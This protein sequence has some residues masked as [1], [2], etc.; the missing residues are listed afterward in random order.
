MVLSG[1]QSEG[2]VIC[3]FV[4]PCAQPALFP[5]RSFVALPFLKLFRGAWPGFAQKFVL[6]GGSTECRVLHRTVFR[7]A[8][9]STFQLA[10]VLAIARPLT[11]ARA[12]TPFG[13]LPPLAQ[14]APTTCGTCSSPGCSTHRAFFKMPYF[15][16]IYTCSALY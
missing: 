14:R 7:C 10:T 5:L 1:Y 3:F 6:L 9:P 12:R 11:F 8:C 4:C 2:V 15:P 16:S 13:T